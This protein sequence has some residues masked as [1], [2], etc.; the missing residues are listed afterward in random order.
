MGYNDEERFAGVIMD[1][2]TS[3]TKFSDIGI[4]ITRFTFEYFF[5]K[6]F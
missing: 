1:F 2:T 5:G 4:E 3:R 6:R